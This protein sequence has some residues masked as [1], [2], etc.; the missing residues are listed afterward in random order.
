MSSVRRS[1]LAT[2]PALESIKLYH[3]KLHA[4]STEELEDIYFH[5]NLLREPLRYRLVQMEMERR[6]L[7]PGEAAV[8][9]PP[10]GWLDRLPGLRAIPALRALYLSG[11]L[12]LSTSALMAVMLV[13]LWLFALPLRFTGIQASL[14]Y[15]VLLPVTPGIGVAFAVRSGGLKP[16]TLAAVGGVVLSLW[17]FYK[18]GGLDAIVQPLYRAGGL[19]GSVF[20]GW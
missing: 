14:V 10:A 8:P 16:R 4:Y 11:V 9:S 15:L 13:P 19:P 3:E 17:L 6:G 2:P 5:I 18:A 7:H 1:Y 12:L 20:G